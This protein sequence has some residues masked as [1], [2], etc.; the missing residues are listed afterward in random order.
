MT[1]R[2]GMMGAGVAAVLLLSGFAFR[3]GGCGG[4]KHD[5]ERGYKFAS[6]RI[7]SKLD[8]LKATEDQKAKIHAIRDR[9]F[10]EVKAAVAEHRATRGEALAQF[11]RGNPDANALKNMVDARLS[12]AKG[13]AYKIVDALVEAHAV[14]TPEQQK[15]L[16]GKLR[17]RMNKHDKK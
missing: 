10:T 1:R 13:V 8:D 5:P 17:E 15:Q 2:F 12:S 11:E 6:W 3:G 4:W 9:V 7:D 16:T 14:L